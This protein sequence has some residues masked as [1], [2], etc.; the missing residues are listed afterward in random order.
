MKSIHLLLSSL[1]ALALVP[2]AAMAAPPLKTHA[3]GTPSAARRAPANVHRGAQVG[4]P[5]TPVSIDVDLRKMP[6]VPAWHP[7]MAIREAHKRQF[8]PLGRVSPATPAS[9]PTV[10]DRLP[11]LQ[12]IWD[13]H[14][15]AK[16]RLRIDGN[17]VSINNG[18]TG[19]S[20]G[21]PVIDVSPNYLVYGINAN[22]GTSFTVYNKAGTKLSGPTAFSS[23]APSSD[24]CSNSVSD[25]IVLF[26]RLAGRWFL[27]EMGGTATS[28]KMCVYISKSE[29]PVSGGWWFYGF[30]T[31]T[32]NDYPHCGVWS[33]AYVCTDNEGGSNVTAYAYDRANM[34]LGATARAQQ[35]FV[36]V[37]ALAGYGFQALTPATYVG[38]SAHAPPSSTQQILARHDDDEA[39]AGASAN[40]SQDYIDLYSIKVDWNSPANSAI[41][42]LPKIPITEYNSWFTDYSTFATVPQPGSTKKLDP[43]REVILNSLVYRNLGSYE[44]IVGQFATNINSARSGSTVNA[45]IRWFELRRVGGGNWTLQQEG[46]YGPGDTSTQHL[47]G[48]IATDNKG[49]IALGYNITRKTTPVTYASL[50]WT[51]RL[52][53]DPAGVMTQ[54]ENIVAP[55]A[56]A[57]TSGRWGDYYAMVVDPSDDCTFWMVGMYRPSTSWNTR[58]A[59]FKFDDCGTAST[60]YAVS[61]TITTSTGTGI[62]GVTVSNGSVSTTTGSGGTFT[63]SSLANG[64]Y[65]IT[66]SLS[67]YSFSP[68]SRSVTVNDGNVSGQDFTGTADASNA[69]PVADFT[70]TTS[71]LAASFTN[72]STDSD[73]SIA[74]QSW[75]FGDS[76]TSTAASPSHSYAAAGTYQVALTVTDN[77]GATN[78]VTKPVTVTAPPQGNVL[79]KAV[80]VTGLAASTGAALEYTFVVPSGATNLTFTMSG[81]TGDADL[82]VKAGSAPTDSVYDCRPYKTGNS[83]SCS[84]ATP[85][86]GTWYVRVKA[87][88]AYSGVSLVADYDTGGGGGG[89]CGGTVLCSGTAIVL[90]AK[91]KGG[92]SSN[93]TLVVPAGASSAVVS[94]SGGTGDAD[95]YVKLGS[96]PTSTSYTCRP[97]L[98]GNNETCTFNAPTAG[99]YYINVRAYSSYS[100]VSL[101]GT[102]SP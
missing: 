56:A 67:G 36:S 37:P 55:G 102:V 86:A 92:V 53:S 94:I 2:A 96:A 52:A 14:A 97:Y 44:S 17:H 78:T 84:F 49:N 13:A 77:D 95:L 81:G 54:G 82:Y 39:H 25:P 61:G 5:V 63:L 90:P 21:D 72:T 59:N 3:P 47:E 75:N 69:N 43:I 73:G 34:L 66:P 18:N 1:L 93:Y 51:G 42:T 48:S 57:E 22:T 26:D 50:G 87:Y 100:G 46:T 24:G 6:V 85:T 23:L 70:F 101:T 60:T 76:A 98:T 7:G 41:T 11:E 45:G 62:S 38:D 64:S 83:E 99:T 20:P 65:T 16:R 27:L 71:D 8:H 12:R 9:T 68:V 4:E 10:P 19:V 79:T 32:Q 29:N 15:P 33:D 35:R 91:S 74:S 58:I 80:P 40:T 30:D 31:P 28:P 88:A 89:S